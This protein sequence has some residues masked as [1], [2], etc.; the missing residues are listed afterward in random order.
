LILP[1]LLT[2]PECAAFLRT[3]PAA[4]YALV[5]R[6]QIPGVVRLGRRILFRAVDLRRHLGLVSSSPSSPPPKKAA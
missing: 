2:V 4:V 1:E 3:T 6:G 5:E